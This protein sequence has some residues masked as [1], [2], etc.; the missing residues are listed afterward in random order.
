MK[1]GLLFSLLI[2][3]ALSTRADI[4]LP[5][6]VNSHMVLQREKP[7]RIWG[8]ADPSE[9]ITIS[10]NKRTV[11]TQTDANGKWQTELPAMKAGGPFQM[12]L[13]GK[14][15]ITLD[16]IL[17]GDVWIC[18]GQSNMEFG[19]NDV[20]NAETEIKNADYPKIRLFSVEKK[21]HL[22]PLEDT[23]GN[24]SACTPQTAAY[25]SAVGYFF[26]RD[27][28]QKINVP[29]GLIS[30]S[31]GGTVAETWISPDGLSGET[32]FGEKAKQTATFDTASFN[33][34][35]R[36]LAKAWTEKFENSDAGSK[37]GKY[38]WA[39]DNLDTKD[40]KP[41]E[42]PKIWG[43]TGIDEFWQLNGVVWFKKEVEL[44]PADL[45]GNLTLSLGIIQ[46]S[47]RVFV[48]GTEVGFTPDI[49]KFRAYQIPASAFNAG[50]NSITVRISN[51]GGDA[52]F[53]AKPSEFYLKTAS[54]QVSLVGTWLYKI[55][56]KL[57]GPGR[58]E[59]EF[60]PNTAPSVLFNTMIN[61]LI[62]LSIKG[63]IWYQGESNT[64]RGFQY[65]DLFKRLITDWR[66]QF[67]QGDF[68][69]L[70]VQLAGLNKKL[71]QP[72]LHSSWAELREAQ[73]MAL[74]LKNT[75]MVTAIDLGDSAN[76]HPKNKQEV[77]RRLALVAEEKVY[78]LPIVGTSP[79][80]ESAQI[81][82][83]SFIVHFSE[84]GTGLKIKDRFTLTGFQIAGADHVFH[85]AKAEIVN[86]NTIKVSAKEVSKPEAVRYAWEDNPGDANLINSENLPAFPFRTDQWK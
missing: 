11:K 86:K 43:F 84:V 22:Q 36:P 83:A 12:I 31:W 8:Y 23:H 81:Q 79:R 66:T 77:G 15:S 19:L 37:D 2:A 42:M 9:N 5:A 51:Y 49:W 1:K 3:L 70:Y 17:I 80:F 39:A 73:D 46:N 68:P 41:V 54:R 69:F 21:V 55:G 27:L 58:P 6:L 25:F 74:S 32:T 35:H 64:G 7:I 13:H 63:V 38:L 14:N 75:A 62:N 20:I 30:A 52:G 34:A 24:W 59:K 45:A 50:K 65:R 28:Q 72:E 53:R 44:S 29:I 16:D 56:Y 61:P 82:D 18:S 85:W 26:G 33:Q 48:N 47:D 60:G 4:R 40:F 78:G 71:K 76:I 57:T 10:F 67:K